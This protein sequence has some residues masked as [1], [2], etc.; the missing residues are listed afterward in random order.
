MS[1]LEPYT[2]GIDATNLRAGG[3]VTHLIELL[4]LANPEMHGFKRI[5]V[6]AGANTLGRIEDRPWLAKRNPAESEKG[7][8]QRTFWQ[9]RR[10]SEAAREEGC[11][12]LFVPGGSYAGDFR[13]IVTMSQNLLPF[14][15]P[16]LLR[17]IAPENTSER[18]QQTLKSAILHAPS[19]TLRGGTREILRGVIARGLGLR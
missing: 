2:I 5:V 19:F 1:E 18:F 8:L 6:W 12:V 9:S 11:D 14:E 16:E 17:L 10:L 13:P 3:G 15:M 7:L 4:R